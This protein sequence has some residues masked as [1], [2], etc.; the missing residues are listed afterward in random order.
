MT[1]RRVLS[2]LFSLA[3]VMATARQAGADL[4][5]KR[6]MK[7]LPGKVTLS[8]GKL[9][10]FTEKRRTVRD[11]D[12]FAKIAQEMLGDEARKK[13]IAALNPGVDAEKPAVGTAL[14][15]PPKVV[16]PA[17]A[18]EATAFDIYHW[19]KFSPVRFERVY[20]GETFAVGKPPMHIVLVPI[21]RR[22][23]FKKLVG[24]NPVKAN[25]DKVLPKT[26]WLYVSEHFNGNETVDAGSKAVG[27]LN[28]L[29]IGDLS[30]NEGAAGTF[31]FVV[32][33]RV[34][35][36]AEGTVMKAGFML[37]DLFE[38]APLVVIS[39]V[40]LFAIAAIMRRRRVVIGS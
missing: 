8:A 1:S 28:E 11:G 10:E 16:D 15:I 7:F 2:L 26:P 37:F 39:V 27:V 17:R 34:R 36:D 30:K 29:S 22:E 9:D 33:K 35:V 13:D 25:L 12:T 23:D 3:V 40:G 5:P 14:L 38:R 31:K 18:T 24:E 6:N 4:M 20:P 32:D 21:A 19:S